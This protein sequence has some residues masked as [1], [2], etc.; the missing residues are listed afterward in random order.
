MEMLEMEMMEM[1]VMEVMELEVM[2]L[3][4]RLVVQVMPKPKTTRSPRTP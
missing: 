4:F 2:C 1:E 3:N